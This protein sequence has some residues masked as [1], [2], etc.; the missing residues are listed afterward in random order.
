VKQGK[1]CEGQSVNPVEKI[2]YNDMI[3]NFI[4]RNTRRMMLFGRSWGWFITL[5]LYL[6][7]KITKLLVLSILRTKLWLSR[8][9]WRW[10][11]CTPLRLAFVWVCSIPTCYPRLLVLKAH[12]K[13][14]RGYC[15]AHQVH[16][17]MPHCSER[18]GG[19]ITVPWSPHTCPLACLLC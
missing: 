4:S 18:A 9:R 14:E 6:L 15:G 10:I 13:T 1:L 7:F 3:E 5:M 11:I 12:T 16:A 2:T 19:T 17:C 8:V